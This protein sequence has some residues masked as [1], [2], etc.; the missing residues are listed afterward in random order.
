MKREWLAAALVVAL[1]VAAIFVGLQ[2][3]SVE[4]DRTLVQVPAAEV[5]LETPSEALEV[6]EVAGAEAVP[7][8]QIPEATETEVAQPTVTA[9]A[10]AAS[11]DGASTEA[12]VAEQTT[13]IEASEGSGETAVQEDVAE[14]AV[15]DDAV[16]TEDVTQTAELTT[17]TTEAET[18]AEE[19][20]AAPAESEV[21]EETAAAPAA[22]E[23]TETTTT[24]ES[25]TPAEDTTET[26]ELAILDAPEPE[27]AEPLTE[28]FSVPSFDLVR[29]ETDGTAIA[30]GRAAPGATVRVL[31]DGVEV[32]RASASSRGEFVAFFTAYTSAAPQEVSLLA[33]GPDDESRSSVEN[34][35]IIVAPSATAEDDAIVEAETEGEAAT[36]TTETPSTTETAAEPLVMRSTADGVEVI[37]GGAVADATQVSFVS[38]SYSVM[39]NVVVTGSGTPAARLIIYIDDAPVGQGR[40][41]DDGRW[42]VVLRDIEAG[43]YTL[44]VDQLN[45][46]DEITSR[47]ETPFQRVFPEVPDEEVEVAEATETQEQAS[48]AAEALPTR[49]RPRRIVVQPGNNLWTI[50]RVELGE[51][52]RFT[53][54]FEANAD[55]I[56]DPDLIYPGQVFTLETTE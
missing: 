25:T 7:T 38:I 50:A 13:A 28:G 53:Q 47:A 56:R 39:G 32:T 11:G 3:Q 2:E 49:E 10:E 14:S 20:S 4:D 8:P 9:E 23:T 42:R 31:L 41:R 18:V 37:S 27:A 48:P 33:D 1:I 5:P 26:T 45:S 44:R 29:V 55:Q 46:L 43:L 34:V 17:K 21:T 12:Q 15:S 52:T 16:N 40:V 54:I 24:T 51:G 22:P 30:A 36:T 35:I 19:T 6:P